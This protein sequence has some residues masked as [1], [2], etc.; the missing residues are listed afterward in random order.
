MK[1]TTSTYEDIDEIFRLYD[2]AVVFQKERF[3]LHWPVF[4][5]SLV[6]TEIAEGR[7]WKILI[8]NTIACVFAITFDDPQIWEERNADKAVYIHRIAT[9]PEYRGKNFVSV[10]VEWAK[11][12]STENGK[13]FVRLDT[14]GDN[15]KLIAHYCKSGFKF[16]GMVTLKDS[17]GLPPHYHNMPVCLFEL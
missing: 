5:R 14:T 3:H 11:K 6:E 7:Q 16:L 12:F 15:K 9:N 13:D 17:T 10:I 4:E 8:D 2:L 1:I